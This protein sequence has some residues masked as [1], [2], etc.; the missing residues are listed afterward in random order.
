MAFTKAGDGIATEPITCTT[1]EAA[2]DF[3]EHIKASVNSKRSV[4]ISWMP[5]KKQNG[6]ITQYTISIRATQDK[7]EITLIKDTQPAHK[8][9]YEVTNLN[10]R[11]SYEVWVS[12]STRIGLGKST[13]P[14]TFS[15]GS[16]VPA[17]ITSFSQ[18]ISVGWGTEISLMCNFVGEPRPDAEWR[19][20]DKLVTETALAKQNRLDISADNVLTLRNVKLS[21]QGNYSCN[22]NNSYGNDTIVYPVAVQLSPSAPKL[23]L[24]ST[25]VDSV[26]LMWD[27][28]DTGGAA[29]RGYNLNYRCIN[30]DWKGMLID[31]QATTYHVERL[32]CGTRYEFQ[33]TAFNKI[34]NGIPSNIQVA[35][36][37]GNR[38][39]SPQKQHLIRSNI[40]TVLVELTAWQDG[41]CPIMYF[42]L[43]YQRYGIEGDY[44][45]VSSHMPPQDR[46]VINDLQPETTYNL[47]ITAYNNAGSTIG[48]YRFDTLTITGGMFVAY[49]NSTFF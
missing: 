19:Y 17:A 4:V 41:G 31:R 36:T 23:N 11:E 15:L 44:I 24:E 30:H 27:K 42:K 28:G 29:L 16:F 45:V 5:P 34:G 48:D 6:I 38:P 18:P 39:I 35:Q 8:L 26:A 9:Y 46:V 33:L 13:I 14:I 49:N 40:T 32:Q 1:D 2:P 20:G 25:T 47:R 10:P 37:K 7:S 21:H 12:A 43:E 3:P 22:V